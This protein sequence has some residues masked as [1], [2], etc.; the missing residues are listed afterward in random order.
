VPSGADDIR[1]YIV[2]TKNGLFGPVYYLKNAD[3]Q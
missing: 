3:F 1:K 2:T